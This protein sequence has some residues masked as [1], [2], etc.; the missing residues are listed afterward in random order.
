M[1]WLG[2]I[3]L[4]S[5]VAYRFIKANR[6]SV[7][8]PPARA[9]MDQGPL[10]PP[11]VTPHVNLDPHLDQVTSRLEVTGPRAHPVRVRIQTGH[12]LSQQSLS[13]DGPLTGEERRVY[14]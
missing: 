7:V 4:F 2:G 9:F 10:D 5:V 1:P 6:A 8:E 13:V 14:E 3:G 12:E 11:P